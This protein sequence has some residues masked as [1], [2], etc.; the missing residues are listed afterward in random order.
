MAFNVEYQLQ[1]LRCKS[2]PLTEEERQLVSEMKPIEEL[3]PRASAEEQLKFIEEKIL[4]NG[5]PAEEEIPT[6]A[7]ESVD[8]IPM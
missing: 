3:L 2:R 6:K 4:G 1:V 8:D 7:P 5:T